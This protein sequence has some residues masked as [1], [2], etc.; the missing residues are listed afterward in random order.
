MLR[1]ARFGKS[2][3]RCKGLPL[4][5]NSEDF[6]VPQGKLDLRKWPTSVDPP[7]KSKEDYQK[8]LESHV[9]HL[10]ALQ[11]LHYASG[12]YAVLLI[13]QGMD[14]VGKDGSIRHVMS[15]VKRWLG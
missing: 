7:F 3:Q 15:G 14:S 12:K 4:K 6:R 2:A 11:Q 5:F 8:I 10:S 9:A 1:D 13:F